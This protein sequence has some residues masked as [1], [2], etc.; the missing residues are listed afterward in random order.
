MKLLLD[1]VLPMGDEPVYFA[2]LRSL[3]CACRLYYVLC[4]VYSTLDIRGAVEFDSMIEDAMRQLLGS[5]LSRE[6]FRELHI[7]VKINTTKF[8]VGIQS[9][10]SL[11]SAAYLCYLTLFASLLRKFV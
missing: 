11:A 2:L 5:S 8:G 1:S 6:S 4:V 7:P 9:D 3:F 10:E